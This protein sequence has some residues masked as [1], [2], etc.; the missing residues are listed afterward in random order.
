MRHICI[1][2]IISALLSASS[3]VWAQDS[4]GNREPSC[5]VVPIFHCAQQL[6]EGN[7]IG[8]FGYDLQCIGDVVSETEVYIDIGDKN[9]FSPKPIDRGQ[10]KVF[11]PGVHI[12]EFEVDFSVA[13]VKRRTVINWSVK[14]QAA[15]VNFSKIKDGS[16]DCS[17]L[18]Q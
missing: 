17:M 10:P 11:L 3:S 12:D 16:L 6:E 13:E 7:T 15:A 9:L 14:G 2:T 5:V 1:L 8:H 4:S 18:P